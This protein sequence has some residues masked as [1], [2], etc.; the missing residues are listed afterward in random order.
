MVGIAQSSN[1]GRQTNMPIDTE[2]VTPVPFVPHSS[3]LSLARCARAIS[4]RAAPRHAS[5][6]NS[7]L[8]VPS[9]CRPAAMNQSFLNPFATA[10]IPE[11]VHQVIG[12][13]TEVSSLCARFNPK[14]R[15]AGQYI[16]SARADCGV[17]IYDLETKGMVRYLEGHV[18][19]VT[20]IA[21]SDTGRYLAS[22]SSD[23]NV[24]L[25]DLK[26]L[27][28]GRIATIRFDAPVSQVSFAPSSSRLLLVTLDSQQVIVVDLRRRR[29]RR[30]SAGQPPAFAQV[31]GHGE[32]NANGDGT[33]AVAGPSSPKPST[34][35]QVAEVRT[36]LAQV[37]ETTRRGQG[38]GD[39]R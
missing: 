9:P 19:P 12:P 11:S 21:W 28:A 35:W 32:G 10:A 37:Y 36:D 24:V 7:S 15:F 20:C 8:V 38:E 39:G 25:W 14:G 18:K 26:Q 17:A 30:R 27:P 13:A 34:T 23:W 6:C 5:S 1:D 16:A 33:E 31:D 22:A 29:K 3:R 4:S 2:R